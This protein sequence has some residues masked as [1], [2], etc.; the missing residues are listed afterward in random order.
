MR[1]KDELDHD[2]EPTPISGEGEIEIEYL[3]AVIL[4]YTDPMAV[5]LKCTI[6]Y[7]FWSIDVESVDAEYKIIGSANYL[8]SDFEQLIKDY[9]HNMPELKGVRINQLKKI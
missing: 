1:E 4:P 7:K 9:L 8:P 6:A 2:I 5:D 3:S